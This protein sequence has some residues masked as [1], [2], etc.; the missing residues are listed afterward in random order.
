MR[1]SRTSN[2]ITICCTYCLFRIKIWIFKNSRAESWKIFTIKL[3]YFRDMVRKNYK[4]LDGFQIFYGW[5]KMPAF[6]WDYVWFIWM[7]NEA[8][9]T[10]KLLR[11]D[12][13]PPQFL[14]GPK[15]LVWLGLSWIDY[16]CLILRVLKITLIF[17]TVIFKHL[18]N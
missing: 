13:S 4:T 18:S 8:L 3:G 7:K 6:I 15:S 5:I 12:S 10:Q 1:A 9:T 2:Y 14:N 17:C 16:C 11:L